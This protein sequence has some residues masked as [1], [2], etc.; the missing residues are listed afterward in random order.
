[1]NLTSEELKYLQDILSKTTSYSIARGEQVDYSTVN[2]KKIQ[3]KIK[4]LI[5]RYHCH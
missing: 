1:M 5:D 2:H 3:E 4:I